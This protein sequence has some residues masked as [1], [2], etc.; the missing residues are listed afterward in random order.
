MRLFSWHRAERIE[1]SVMKSP[2]TKH[3]PS[4]KRLPSARL[5]EEGLHAGSPNHK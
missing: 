3:L 2:N 4:P 5:L 1:H